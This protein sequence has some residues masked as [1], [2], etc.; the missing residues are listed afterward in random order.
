M[1]LEIALGVVA[2]FIILANL[3]SLL[4]VLGVLAALA[5]FVC[6]LAVLGVNTIGGG[7]LAFY[8]LFVAYL[9]GNYLYVRIFDKEKYNEISRRIYK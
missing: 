9:A 7:I 4:L 8:A 2:G 1:I 3:G 6:L 5:L